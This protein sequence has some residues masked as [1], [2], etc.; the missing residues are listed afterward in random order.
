MEYTIADGAVLVVT[1]VS[2]LLAFTRGFTREALAIGG[3]ILAAILALYGA[4]LVKPILKETPTI[5]D[6]LQRNCNL[7]KLVAF[8][9]VFAIALIF[10]SIFTPLFSSAVRESPLGA[11]DKA[12]GF[13]FGLAR[14][15]ALVAVA[16]LIYAQIMPPSE[17]LPAIEKA[18]SVALIKEAANIIENNAPRTVPD[19]IR[20]PVNQ[21]TAECGGF[22]ELDAPGAGGGALTPNGRAAPAER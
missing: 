7:S 9:V 4:P 17:R 5:G 22:F 1:L 16:W 8:A 12:L 2:G 21:L 15:V 14:G 18:R 13:L 6:I 10:L 11:V 3:W 20:R 19:W